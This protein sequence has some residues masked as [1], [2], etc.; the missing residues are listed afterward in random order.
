MDPT[1]WNANK[2]Q[3]MV[4]WFKRPGDS[5]IPQQKEQLL[6][7]YLLTCNW[8]EQERNRFKEGVDPVIDEPNLPNP[9][10]L[11]EQPAT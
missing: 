7:R 4:P 6:Q 10:D 5:K 2:L 3:A 1:K 11:M 9:D 8:S